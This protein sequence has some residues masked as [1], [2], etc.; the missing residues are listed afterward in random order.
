MLEAALHI[1]F[2]SAWHVGS[3]LGDGHLSDAIL[4]RDHNG[5]PVLPGRAVK[6]ALR[7]G[8]WRMALCRPDLLV[9]EDY[10]WGSRSIG[11]DSNQPGRLF[12]SAAELPSELRRELLFHPA[13]EREAFVRDMTCMQSQTALTP[14]LTAKGHSLR[15]LECGIPG[16]SFDSVMQVDAPGVDPDWLRAYFRAVCAATKSM[17]AHRARGLGAC[18]IRLDGHDDAVILP[19]FCPSEITVTSQGANA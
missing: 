17:G 18:R 13:P 14:Q 9:A 7:E 10:F 6:G 12:V 3:G 15:V 8:A 19:P 1:D 11:A 16:I 5:L 2:I 4:A